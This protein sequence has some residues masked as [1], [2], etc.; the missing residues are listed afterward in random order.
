[1]IIFILSSLLSIMSYSFIIL[2]LAIISIVI[3][4]S[5]LFSIIIIDEYFIFFN[6]IY[7][8]LI[9]MFYLLNVIYV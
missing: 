5:D 2:L 9:K 6:L 3:S 7:L 1:M 8:F 4:D